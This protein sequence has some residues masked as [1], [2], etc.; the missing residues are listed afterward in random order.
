MHFLTALE[1]DL[2]HKV[3]EHGEDFPFFSYTAATKKRSGCAASPETT[4]SISSALN[5]R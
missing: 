3:F 2:P 1:D 5:G 4:N